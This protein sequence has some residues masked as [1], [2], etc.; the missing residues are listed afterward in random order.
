MAKNLNIKD[1]IRLLSLFFIVSFL[2]Q[3]CIKPPEYP[4]EPVVSFISMS[5]DTVIQG[6]DSNIIT[7]G[8]TDG[9]GDLGLASTEEGENLFLTDITLGRVQKFRIPKIPAQGIGNGIS[10]KI[11]I[12]I[13]P[14]SMCC[15]SV[16]IP[17]SPEVGAA[18]ETTIYTVKIVDR[19]GNESETIQLPPLRM[20]CDK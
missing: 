6:V 15:D 10:G 19:A 1:I 2:W 4:D 7:I 14:N 11:A 5:R 17:C 12:L 9:D 8:F 18:M 16:T 20:V 3:S 13:E